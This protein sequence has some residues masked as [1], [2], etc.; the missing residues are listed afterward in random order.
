M[1]VSLVVCFNLPTIKS[2]I[3]W[4]YV[5]FWLTL[6]GILGCVS[7]FLGLVLLLW[8]VIYSWLWIPSPRVGGISPNI[9]SLFFHF[10]MNHTF[11]PFSMS[12]GK[13]IQA[14][15]YIG[16]RTV[17]KVSQKLAHNWL[18]YQSFILR[19]NLRRIH[20]YVL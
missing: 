11:F 3:C 1:V 12:M 8:Y 18:F 16:A 20:T 5:I 6:F 19:K 2:L 9:F 10:L 17:N 15:V 13:K 7:S 14:A 4:Y